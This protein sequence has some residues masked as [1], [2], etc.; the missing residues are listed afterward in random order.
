MSNERVADILEAL[1]ERE[2]KQAK[3]KT[4]TKANTEVKKAKKLTKKEQQILDIEKSIVVPDNY[5]LINTPELLERFVN[6]YKAYKTMYQDE[7]YVFLDTETYGLNN[8]R[9]GLISIQIGFM[10]EQYFYIPMRPFKHPMSKDIPT[11]DFDTVANAL[12][13]LLE[14]DKLLVLAN[15][16]L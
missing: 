10:S 15:A 3:K 12:R 8:W 2:E 6:Y 9:D 14:A 13:P 16:K 5:I 1:G 4:R 7:A 11:L